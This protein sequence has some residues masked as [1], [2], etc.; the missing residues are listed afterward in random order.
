MDEAQR[1]IQA[2][3]DSISNTKKSSEEL[4]LRYSLLSSAASVVPSSS[5]A[6]PLG[7]WM[8]TT[9]LS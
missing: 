1:F 8:L 6:L 9:G 2:T 3:Q 4:I 5:L 7:A